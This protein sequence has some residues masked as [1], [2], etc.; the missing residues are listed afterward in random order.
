MVCGA[1]S[2][3]Y[4]VADAAVVA[5]LDV[6]AATYRLRRAPTG[7]AAHDQGRGAQVTDANALA[8]PT[9]LL[10]DDAFYSLLRQRVAA[11]LH[12]AGCAAGGPTWSCVTLF[13][14]CFAAWCCAGVLLYRHAT[15]ACAVAH[16]LAASLV[17]AFGHNWVHQPRYKLWAYLS[18]DTIG[19]SSDGW[20][21]EHILQHHM[22]ASK[23]PPLP[24]LDL[25]RSS[26]F[27]RRSSSSSSLAGSRQRRDPPAARVSVGHAREPSRASLGARATSSVERAP[28][29]SCPFAALSSR[30]R[31]AARRVRFV[32]R[33]HE[34]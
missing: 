20:F 32:P 26:S 11:H 27:E 23:S 5:A 19:F 33:R 4:A 29:S 7:D 31:S 28:R 34:P 9:R 17:G 16:G 14:A 10:G 1:S 24:L 3:R 6:H 13:W 12:A 18:L 2:V 21:R 15:L 22:C 30:R 25:Y 8:V